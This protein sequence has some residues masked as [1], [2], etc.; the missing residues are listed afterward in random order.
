MKELI[1]PVIGIGAG[2]LLFHSC[3]HVSAT[4]TGKA[5]AAEMCVHMK[6]GQDIQQ[7]LNAL[8]A[9]HGKGSRKWQYEKSH[10]VAAWTAFRDEFL[11][12]SGIDTTS[13]LRQA[14][15]I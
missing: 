10:K 12:C 8:Q 7:A 1:G 13:A 14:G 9:K 3:S 15:M 2:L 11:E 6:D 5:F 4:D